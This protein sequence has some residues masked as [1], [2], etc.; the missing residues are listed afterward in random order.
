MSQALGAPLV[1]IEIN[2]HDGKVAC[3]PIFKV[4]SLLL[5]PFLSSEQCFQVL[6]TE[7][8]GLYSGG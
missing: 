4:M 7:N 8:Y 3:I 5:L 6:P 2:L 1:L